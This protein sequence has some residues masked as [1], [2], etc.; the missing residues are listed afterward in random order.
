MRIPKPSAS[1]SR[2]A[3]QKRQTTDCAFI[4]LVDVLDRSAWRSDLLH[5][6][7]CCH[8][9]LRLLFSW[10]SV[11]VTMATLMVMLR[12]LGWLFAQ[13]DRR[14]FC[15]P[16]EFS[17]ALGDSDALTQHVSLCWQVGLPVA[18]AVW[19]F[20]LV[21]LLLRLCVAALWCCAVWFRV[22]WCFFGGLVLKAELLMQC[23]IVP[24]QFAWFCF[25]RILFGMM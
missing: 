5:I 12:E 3:S 25:N 17:S 2:N 23:A 14:F 1:G 4:R 6:L 8:N 19:L 10:V 15:S 20:G 7:R 13:T 21:V 16:L 18:Y 11:A 9:V 22:W 24:F